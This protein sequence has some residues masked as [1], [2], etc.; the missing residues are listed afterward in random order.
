MFFA[1]QF[2]DFDNYLTSKQLVQRVSKK[3]KKI[4]VLQ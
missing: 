4:T 2:E 1:V 3:N